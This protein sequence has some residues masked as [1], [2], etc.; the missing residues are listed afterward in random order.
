[1][2]SCCK[3]DY[4]NPVNKTVDY[5]GVEMALD[6]KG[7]FRVRCYNL[8]TQEMDYMDVINVRYCP[9]CGRRFK[10]DGKN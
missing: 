9:M 2:C 7:E 8:D 6:N 4:F 5:S 3:H 1:M 10:N